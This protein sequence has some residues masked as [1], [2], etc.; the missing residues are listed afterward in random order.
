M[1][2]QLSEAGVTN[3]KYVS[4]FKK[5][6][7]YPD[8]E[9]HI[10]LRGQNNKIRFVFLSR[11]HPDKGCDYILEAAEELNKQGLKDRFSVDFYGK[12]EKSYEESFLDKIKKIENVSYKGVLNLKEPAGYDTLADYEAMLFPTFHPSEGFAG[13]FID[14]FIAGVPVLASDWAY[15][16]ECIKDGK[17]GIIYPPHDVKALEKVMDDCIKGNVNLKQMAVN[18]RAE[19]PKFEAQNV[20]NKAYLKEIGLI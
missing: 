18:V 7:Y 20:I 1:I 17:F 12:F 4:N 19:A 11:I 10:S 2:R 16:A 15:N 13:I 9:K 3:G 8:F 14:A 6:D 5:I